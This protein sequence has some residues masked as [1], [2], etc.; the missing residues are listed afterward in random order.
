MQS[1]YLLCGFENKISESEMSNRKMVINQYISKGENYGK[2]N[3]KKK[4]SS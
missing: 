4:K 2:D 1:L 3:H